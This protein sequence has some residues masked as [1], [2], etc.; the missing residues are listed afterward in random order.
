MIQILAGEKAKGKAK[1]KSIKF[2]LFGQPLQ[3]GFLRKPAPVILGAGFLQ[4]AGGPPI[5]G[6]LSWKYEFLFDIISHNIMTL[7]LT[8]FVGELIIEHFLYWLTL[9]LSFHS[10]IRDRNQSHE[11]P[12][13]GI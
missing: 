6:G 2:P 3:I 4:I 9:N 5:K 10:N 12:I 1:R 7:N 11:F 8:P 13:T